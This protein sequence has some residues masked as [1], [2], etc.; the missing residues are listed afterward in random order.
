ML[1]GAAGG[2]ASNYGRTATFAQEFD[3]DPIE[4]LGAR[5]PSADPFTH[6]DRK[7]YAASITGQLS[8]GTYLRLSVE[9]FILNGITSGSQF[10]GSQSHHRIC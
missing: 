8:A 4:L 1:G 2:A 5:I 6:D 9:C 10:T 3:L 7:F